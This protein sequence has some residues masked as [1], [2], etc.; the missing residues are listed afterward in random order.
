MTVLCIGS[1][2]SCSAS[3]P[4]GAVGWSAVCDC[5]TSSSYYLCIPYLQI[6]LF[7]Q[8]SSPSPG[9]YPHLYHTHFCLSGEKKTRTSPHKKYKKACLHILCK[10]LVFDPCLVI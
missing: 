1:V 6:I 4:H 2:S 5:G 10:E 7:Y 9:R 8:F 3:L